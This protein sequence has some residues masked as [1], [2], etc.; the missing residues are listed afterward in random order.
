MWVNF[1]FLSL[2]LF[3]LLGFFLSGYQF[4]SVLV[5]LEN[6]NILILIAS[7]YWDISSNGICFLLFMIIATIE[8]VLSLV[9]LS[10]VWSHTSL[11]Y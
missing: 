6:L 8:V 2:L 4:L 11:I 5:V 7:G 10:R 3:S 9:V 1:L